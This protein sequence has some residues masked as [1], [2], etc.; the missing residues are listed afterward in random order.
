MTRKVSNITVLLGF[1]LILQVQL[2][3][4]NRR[5]LAFTNR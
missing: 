4:S 5:R 3:N 2:Q 1:K